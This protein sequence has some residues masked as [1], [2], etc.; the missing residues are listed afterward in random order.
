MKKILK[1]C[2]FCGGEASLSYAISNE[3]KSYDLV[4]CIGCGAQGSCYSTIEDATEA[5]NRRSHE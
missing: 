5:W 4:Q 2:P 1:P 3:N